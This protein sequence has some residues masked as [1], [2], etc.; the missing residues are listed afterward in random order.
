MLRRVIILG[1]TG[2]I[3]RQTVET[4]DHLNALFVRGEH[5]HEYQIVGLAAGR[6]TDAL[7]R[8]AFDLKVVDVA[9]QADCDEP[10]DL[11]L[12]CGDSAA[13]ELVE[14]VPCDIVVAAIVGS[15]GLKATLA[16]ARLGRRVA[17]ANKE[18][19]VA[20][21]EL[22][23][24][25]A[26]RSGAAILPVDSEHSGVWQCLSGLAPES[27]TPPLANS[28]HGV[29]RVTLTASGGPFRTWD[30]ARMRA[31]TPEEALKHPVWSM[32]AKVTIDSASLMNKALEIIEARWL[33][34]LSP[35]QLAGVIHPQSIVHAMIELASGSTLAQLGRPDMRTPIL[36]ALAWPDLPRGLCTHA[37][38]AEAGRL[39]FEPINPER[40]PA[41]QYA[42]HAMA[43]GG[44]AGAVLNAANEAAVAAFLA[45]R[46]KFG[47]IAD[48]VGAA[49]APRGVGVSPLRDLDDLHQAESEARRFV[50]SSLM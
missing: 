25:L 1:S 14:S 42:F 22:F 7:I 33:F 38:L 43:A 19:L 5:P 9:A 34:G 45:G 47:A 32:G 11:R 28:P 8:Q 37:N 16:A 2:S 20:A 15:A 30:I 48:T 18:T 4:I 10:S 13:A 24:P 31:A 27:V 12:R 29:A 3:G 21:G 49:I 35:D 26:Q 6:Q 41:F 39:D 36:H 23:V 44:T 50:E 46:C 17:L 40:F